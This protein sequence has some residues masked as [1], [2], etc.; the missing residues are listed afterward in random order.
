M[1]E[2]K[3]G[4]GRPPKKKVE[5]K[6][7]ALI[8]PK[9]EVTSFE[10]VTLPPLSFQGHEQLTALLEERALEVGP[11]VAKFEARYDVKLVFIA[12]FKAFKC[13]R[14]KRHVDWITLN[15]LMKRYD[16]RIKPVSMQAQPQRPYVKKRIY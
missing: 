11:L 8:K 6:Q 4:R 14:E 9:D 3:R 15:E 7:V 1:T 2:V 5:V 16:C 13:M 10:P 12:K